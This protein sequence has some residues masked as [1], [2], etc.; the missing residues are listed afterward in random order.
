MGPIQRIEEGTTRNGRHGNHNIKIGADF[1]RNIENSL[2]SVARPSYEF[3]DPLF[4]AADAPAE[5]DAGVDP[6]ICAPPCSSFNLSPTPQLAENTRH[7]RN[8]EFGAYFQDDW[9][10]TKN[11][12]LNLGI[13][14]D[15]FTRHNEEDNLATTF[16]T[17]PGN[18]LL[19]GVENANSFAGCPAD[20][21]PQQIAQVA[22][23]KGVCGPGGFAP[24]SSLGKGDH[25]NIGPRV[26]FAYDVFGD[27]KM[28][29]RGGFGVSYEGTLYNPLSNSRWNMNSR[30]REQS[31]AN[32]NNFDRFAD[33]VRASPGT[34]GR[35]H[36][37][38]HS[39]GR[40]IQKET[41]F[42]LAVLTQR[43]PMVADENDQ[44]TCIQVFG[45][46]PRDQA[47]NFAIRVGDLTVIRVSLVLRSKGFGRI[48][49]TVWIV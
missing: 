46:E 6:G 36:D 43:L 39:D 5:E 47:A 25:N 27:G 24:A 9:K 44:R 48:V 41:V 34:R 42:L 31:R 13:R 33:L 45:F 7:W 16:I 17:G 4:F 26:G 1:R 23:L 38:R 32:G 28:A 29:L 12:T 21:T 11:F 2:F 18:S 15:L 35:F 20:F 22:Q 30:E 40:V 19:E 3:F 14:Y 8:L 10:V 37:Q 49:W